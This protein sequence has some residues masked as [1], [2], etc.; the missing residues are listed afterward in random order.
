MLMIIEEDKARP[1]VTL[2]VVPNS[3]Y[4]VLATKLQINDL[5]SKSDNNIGNALEWLMWAAYEEGKF[6][7]LIS[8]LIHCI[9]ESC[10]H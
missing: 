4:A 8:F 3:V 9:R 7:F 1:N 10:S 5:T 6:H 2:K